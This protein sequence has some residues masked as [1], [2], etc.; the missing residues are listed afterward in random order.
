MKYDAKSYLDIKRLT[1][2]FLKHIVLS[3][4]PVTGILTPVVTVVFVC[5]IFDTPTYHEIPDS[6][7]AL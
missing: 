6:L 2:E 3:F 7:Q 5:G 4:W 1:E